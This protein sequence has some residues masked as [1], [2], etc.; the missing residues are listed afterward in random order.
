MKA[1]PQRASRRGF[2]LPFPRHNKTEFIANDT[3]LCAAC[4]RCVAA[5][6]RKVLGTIAIGSHCH[7]HVDH[8]AACKGCQRCVAAC[9]QQA[10]RTCREIKE[11][12]NHNPKERQE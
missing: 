2:H 5:C 3:G 4:G 8:A 12:C 1:V 9:R 10:I 7:V 6:P 11:L